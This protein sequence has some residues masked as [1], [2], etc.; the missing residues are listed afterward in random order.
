MTAELL[1]L[2]SARVPQAVSIAVGAYGSKKVDP[3]NLRGER[4]S[5]SFGAIR[6]AV[7]RSYLPTLEQISRYSSCCRGRLSKM[8]VSLPGNMWDISF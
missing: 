5:L 4:S 1:D 3:G 8:E 7:V 6:K 2:Y